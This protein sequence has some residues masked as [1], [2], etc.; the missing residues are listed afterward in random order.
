MQEEEGRWCLW[1]KEEEPRKGFNIFWIK[2]LLNNSCIFKQFKDIQEKCSWSYVA[3]QCI[4][5]ER[6]YRVH[7]SRWWREWIELN[8]KKWTYSRR[9][10]PQRRKTSRFST[11]VNPMEDEN[12]MAEI[13]RD[14]TKPRIAPYKNI[15]RRLQNTEDW[16]NLKFAQ[17]KGLHFLIKHGHM[18]SFSGTH[19]LQLALGKRYLWKHRRSSTKRF[20]CFQEYHGLYSERT[21]NTVNK[22]HEAK[23]QDHLGTHQRFEELRRNL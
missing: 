9:A 20:A 3:R 10:K 16:C 22:I 21:R 11:T 5:T 23:K 18:Q 19:Y 8:N 17:E 6:I 7:L 1:Q 15:W 2:T 12:R 13:P 14:L 4:V